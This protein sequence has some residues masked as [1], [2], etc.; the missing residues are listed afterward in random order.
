[1]EPDKLIIMITNKNY[2]VNR[3][4]ELDDLGWMQ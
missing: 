1:M 2:E 4:K 3:R